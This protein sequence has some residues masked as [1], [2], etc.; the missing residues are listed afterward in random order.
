MDCILYLR[1]STQRQG[2]SGLGLEGQR[3][4]AEKFL[5]PDD[6]IISEYIEVENGD[7]Q[8]ALVIQ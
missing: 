8:V 2:I 1:A 5:G 6:R 7:K 3:L 4:I